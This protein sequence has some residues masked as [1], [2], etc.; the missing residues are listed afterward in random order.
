MEPKEPEGEELDQIAWIY[1]EPGSKRLKPKPPL[2][3]PVRGMLRHNPDK[4]DRDRHY[5]GSALRDHNLI[6]QAKTLGG[7]S[8]PGYRS[9]TRHITSDITRDHSDRPRIWDLTSP[10]RL[11]RKQRCS[12]LKM[13]CKPVPWEGHTGSHRK[14]GRFLVLLTP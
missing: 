13:G 6:M 1:N 5:L 3:T 12:C 10:F 8:T 4:A 14:T 9:P 7:P 2:E 11:F